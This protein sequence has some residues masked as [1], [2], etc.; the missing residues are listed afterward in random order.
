VRSRS[1]GQVEARFEVL[2]GA[3]EDEA[4]LRLDDLAKR[5]PD[6]VLVVDDDDPR[7]GGFGCSAIRKHSYPLCTRAFRGN[8]LEMPHLRV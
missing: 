4:G 8:S 6:V 1:E 5:P 7:P 2:G 3:D